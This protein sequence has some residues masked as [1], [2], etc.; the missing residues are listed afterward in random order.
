[1]L[2]NGLLEEILK[3]STVSVDK[4]SDAID[5]H[6]QILVT[7]KPVTKGREHA[8]GPRLIGVF[9]YGITKASNPC[10]RVFEYAGDTATFIPN[11]KFLR[12]DSI[13]SWKPTG[14]TIDELPPNRYGEFNPDGDKTMAMV[15]KVAKFSD[16]KEIPQSSNFSG[17]ITN[18]LYRTDAEKGILKRRERIKQQF[19]NPLTL[20]DLE[21]KN[22]LKDFKDDVDIES[23]PITTDKVKGNIYKTDTEKALERMKNQFDKHEKIDLSQFDKYKKPQNDTVDNTETNDDNT[24]QKPDLFKT[25]TEKNLE[26]MKN[27]FGKHEKIDLSQ[28]DKYKRKNDLRQKLGNTDDSLT[29][30]ELDDRLRGKKSDLGALKRKY[31]L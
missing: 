25:D 10:I 30:K 24:P 15:Y 13:L 14:R 22:G 12:I 1:M 16:E 21:K 18:N 8:T 4:I 28:F 6:Q 31:G 5:N 2:F 27:Q 29:K 11:W 23:G 3:E 19:D 20:S 26:R 17:P 9:A 7:Y